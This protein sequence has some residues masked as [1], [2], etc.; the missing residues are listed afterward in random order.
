MRHFVTLL[1]VAVLA[2]GQTFGT[3]PHAVAAPSATATMS[4]AVVD[5]MTEAPLV[6]VTITDVSATPPATALTDVTGHYT[7]TVAPGAHA[8]TASLPGYVTGN[9]PQTTVA[10]GAT[11]NVNFSL[12]K[13]ASA[14]GVVTVSGTSTG[15]GSV[16]VKFF[17]DATT[18]LNPVTTAMTSADGHW[19]TDQL[20]PGT[21]E[22]QFISLSG[23][24]A[25]T[26]YASAMGR[27]GAQRVG[28]AAGEALVL[29]QALLEASRIT[30]TIRD[31]AG[32]PLSN[33]SIVARSS[34]RDYG[35]ATS[36]ASGHYEVLGLQQDAYKLS[37]ELSGYAKTWFGNVNNELA[38][39]YIQVPLAGVVTDVGVVLDRAGSISGTVTGPAGPN[40]C[41][42]LAYRDGD[43]TYA[44]AP[45]WGT[46]GTYTIPSLPIG[47]YRVYF[48]ATGYE[49]QW[50]A[51]ATSQETAT[52][53]I[54]TADATTP[55]VDVTMIAKVM[56]L[57]YVIGSVVDLDGNPLAGVTVSGDNA[58][59]PT[60]T[61]ADGTYTLI[62]H[63]VEYW[64]RFS[65]TGYIDASQPV[66][67][68]STYT[69]DKPYQNAPMALSRPGTLS[70]RVT[71]GSGNTPLESAV[72]TVASANA[73]WSGVVSTASDGTFSI[74]VPEGN[75][76]VEA[77][78]PIGSGL[79]T[80]YYG[81]TTIAELATYV[82]VGQG[83]TVSGVDIHL[84]KTGSISGNVRRANG[85]PAANDGVSLNAY[86]FAAGM[87]TDSAGAF[88]IAGIPPG[89]Y[90]IAAGDGESYVYWD[91]ALTGNT[92]SP[93]Q[94][95]GNAVSGIILDFSVGYTL[96]GVLYDSNGHIMRG[97][98]MWLGDSFG[99][100][101]QVVTDD[102][103]VYAF[104][105]LA[106]GSYSV[107]VVLD[108][109][110]F[111]LPGT[112]DDRLADRFDLSS[113]RLMDVTA[114]V[115]HSLA[116]T[117]TG[118]GAD[119]PIAGSVTAY[120]AL[121]NPVAW[122]SVSDG[123]ATLSLFPGTYTIAA[124][125]DG[126]A[127]VRA[128]ITV[129]ST[130]GMT[131]ELLRGGRI[132]GTLTGAGGYIVSAQ[133]L[134][135]GKVF[136][137][138]TASETYSLSGLTDGEYVVAAAPSQSPDATW[139]V[140]CGFAV[141]FGGAGFF[142]ATRIQVTNGSVTDGVDMAATCYT[143]SHT[144]A[145]S[146]VLPPGVT[147]TDANVSQIAMTMVSLDSNRFSNAGV[148]RG[149]TLTS[150]G[151]FSFS[152][153]PSGSYMITVDARSIGL[154]AA[155]AT[156]AVTADVT[157]VR[158][159]PLLGGSIAGR[160]VNAFGHGVRGVAV[161]GEW[162]SGTADG[163]ID[164]QGDFVLNGLTPGDY[165]VRVTP[166]SPY[167]PETVGNVHVQSGQVT[168]I[169][170]VTL[171]AMSRIAG[172]VP[173]DTGKVRIDAVD[174]D[175]R[176][177]DWQ[178]T[179][180][181]GEYVLV[182]PEGTVYVRFSGDSIVTQWW[183]ESLTQASATPV[184][185]LAG[186]AVG[187]I[188]L[189]H[190]GPGSTLQTATVSGSVTGPLGPMQGVPI[191]A[192]N[193]SGYVGGSTVTAADGAYSVEV[194]VGDTYTVGFGVCLGMNL[195]SL[196]CLSDYY[197]DN[198]RVVVGADAVIGVDFVIVPTSLAFSSTPVPTISGPP[199]A[200]Q[201]LTAAPGAWT[202]VP[203]TTTWQWYA[204]GVS[205]AGATASTLTLTVDHVGKAITVEA[206]GAKTGYVTA[207]RLSD[208]TAVV[209]TQRVVTPG[210][211]SISGTAQVG[212]SLTAVPGTWAPADVVLT[213]AWG[214][215]ANLI[216]GA[217]NATYQPTDADVGHT[218]TVALTG[219]KDGY[220]SATAVSPATVVVQGS[221]S[222]LAYGPFVKASYKDFL[223]RLPSAEEVAFQA[224]ALSQGRVSKADYLKS[225][226][227]SNEW[228]SEIVTKMYRDTLHRDP[229][230]AGLAD[231]V[232][233]LR[234]G[235]FT[236]AEAASRFYSSD[237][238]YAGY[239]RDT[240][241]W[242]TALYG[243]LLLRGPDPQGLQFWITMTSTH[244]RDWVAYNFYQSQ[245]SRSLRV[246]DMYAVLLNREPDPVGLPFWTARVLTTGDL[247]LAWE[248]ANSQEYW[249][250]ALVRYGTK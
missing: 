43:P 36:D 50:Y 244:G 68:S 59:I 8:L 222:V 175:G 16:A 131:M 104:H 70:G 247:A 7:L 27:G 41:T 161:T 201:T 245:E 134:T 207:T 38:A 218:L 78:A 31:A 26:W 152:D 143:G 236:V 141:W 64:L 132:T 113:D 242:V 83:S 80:T 182:V 221:T 154:L 109:H 71:G 199:I 142:D 114:P 241:L 44:S 60:T 223:G 62:V 106:A 34:V 94:V 98:S 10:D 33:A 238:Y 125:A 66:Y 227:T 112:T 69:A 119:A 5:S 9:S 230:P 248:I 100:T 140:T 197:H 124:T 30:G 169:P 42:I 13:Y 250:K 190:V 136:R 129:P 28:V 196:G 11:A 89:S 2:S 130:S 214:R 48:S 198:R 153:V 116:I 233:W 234:S 184:T 53:V 232:S 14:S 160:V 167:M 90:T 179:H 93:I 229:D 79:P 211:V 209:T 155:T 39:D 76:T 4:G 63:A 138:T 128:T 164:V 219:A 37:V 73:E 192:Y 156:V 61:A 96:T 17:D 108:S 82:S 101:R 189:M 92:A 176:V 210:S 212:S 226:S 6:N 217:T 228:L 194:L 137:V 85:E 58:S 74:D 202:P 216:P 162:V 206:T 146:L 121:S 45:V 29:S 20:V 107:G 163:H 185:I 246:T 200:G 120:N 231:W 243:A 126:F 183:K 118:E 181:G 240:S 57:A 86:G 117:V 148:L 170:T 237:E 72:V 171:R 56:P 157:G 127:T 166:P 102:N 235:R 205:I 1:S 95:D 87:Q 111:W 12:V 110:M 191:T 186:Q 84:S 215:D 103:G 195:P 147:L 187:G 225:L 150:S 165:A 139:Y 220:A 158:I 81:G 135:T 172:V 19:S 133:N 88:T 159:H 144:V 168:V 97:T 23:D 15:I 249:D 25:T 239:G 49:G 46:N 208:P 224:T 149:G 32:N 115:G 151:A 65:K 145:G 180:D 123:S 67:V 188:N 22:V 193:S 18:N 40:N 51:E 47:T 99:W 173:P 177:L 203:D 75:V 3:A 91:G 122:A 54:V 35:Y 52:P 24:Y 204:N 174:G 55:S 213:Y 105:T 21:Y 178:T 77:Q